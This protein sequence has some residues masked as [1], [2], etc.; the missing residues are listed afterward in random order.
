MV[1]VCSANAF[2][3]KNDKLVYNNE[4]VNGLMMSQTVY[5][6]EGNVLTNYMQ[7]TYKYDDQNRMTEN[8][9]MKW[10]SVKN[11]WEND[12]SIRYE[13]EGKMVTTSYYKWNKSKKE[14]QL[15]PE[16]TVTMDNT[17]M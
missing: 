14:F 7:Y 16:M 15:I 8:T 3:D 4:E 9:S 1:M 2:A 11:K 5:K 13:Y 17:N 10:N 6:N 12:M